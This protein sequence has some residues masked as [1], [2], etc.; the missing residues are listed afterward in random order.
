MKRD[1]IVNVNL[2]DNHKKVKDYMKQSDSLNRSKDLIVDDINKQE[3]SFKQRLEEKKKSKL[4]SSFIME[5]NNN[6]VILNDDY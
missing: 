1:Y 2:A 4:S 6:N 5:N 3:N